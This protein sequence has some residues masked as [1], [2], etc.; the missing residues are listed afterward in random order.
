MSCRL[1]FSSEQ[2]SEIGSKLS[3]RDASL[4][5]KLWQEAFADRLPVF[6]PRQICVGC[7]NPFRQVLELQ[8]R[9]LIKP[10]VP[11]GVR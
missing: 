6:D 11:N 7:S 8:R 1:G 4:G 10:V 3:R 5:L 9:I 2:L